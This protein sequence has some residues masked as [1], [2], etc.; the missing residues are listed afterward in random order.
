[1]SA[2]IKNVTFA[3]EQI[4]SAT[5]VHLDFVKKIRSELNSEK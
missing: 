2:F 3:D 4:A 5:D 1:M